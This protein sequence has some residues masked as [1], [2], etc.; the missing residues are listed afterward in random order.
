MRTVLTLTCV[1]MAG[2]AMTWGPWGL[3]AAIILAL[4]AVGC[5]MERP[6]TTLR[7]GFDNR[8]RREGR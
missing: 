3:C 5:F 4:C 2:M 8:L 7:R 1:G 6:K